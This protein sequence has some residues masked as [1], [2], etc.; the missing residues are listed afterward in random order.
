MIFFHLQGIVSRMAFQLLFSLFSQYNVAS[1]IFSWF[2]L[3][4]LWLTFSIIIELL[5]SQSPAV[6]LFGTADIVSLSRFSLP[7]SNDYRRTG[8]TRASNGYTLHSSRYRC[9]D[10]FC[11]GLRTNIVQFVLALGN[12][13][14]GEKITYAITLWYVPAESSV[15]AF[16]SILGYSPSSHYIS[17]YALS[18]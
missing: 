2:A 15:R 18:G 1:L 8:S 16:T 14:K 11:L 9:V 4:N 17:F 13:P 10:T 6:N 3:A 5:P 7:I 12:R